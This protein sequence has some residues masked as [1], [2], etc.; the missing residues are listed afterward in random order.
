M[1]NLEVSLVVSGRRVS[2]DSF[3]A[4]LA[5]DIRLEVQ[6]EIDRLCYPPLKTLGR[7]GLGGGAALSDK[8]VIRQLAGRR[9]HGT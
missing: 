2:L 5:G 8:A 4:A 1:L 9:N 3:S 7:V 6:E